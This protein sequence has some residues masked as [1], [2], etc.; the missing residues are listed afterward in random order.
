M[1]ARK[2][3][4]LLAVVEAYI[5]TGKP[6]GSKIISQLPQIHVSAATERNDMGKFE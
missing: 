2:K 4:V 5:Q 6:V 3:N 1:D